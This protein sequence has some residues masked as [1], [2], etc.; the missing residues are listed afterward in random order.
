MTAL[1]EDLETE[2]KD[3]NTDKPKYSHY[4][5]STSVTEGYVLGTPVMALCGETFVPSRD[6]KKFPVCPACKNIAEAL[7]LGVD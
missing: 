5:E 3:A 6:P 1:L 7:F 4:A 2:K